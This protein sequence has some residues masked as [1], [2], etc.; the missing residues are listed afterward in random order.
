[1]LKL[2]AKWDTEFGEFIP[3]LRIA[4]RH[5]RDDIGIRFPAP[6]IVDISNED[7]KGMNQHVLY[8]K[9]ARIKREMGWSSS[10]SSESMMEQIYSILGEAE[11]ILSILVPDLFADSVFSKKKRRRPEIVS[12]MKS[13]MLN[14]KENNGELENNNDDDDVQWDSDQ[15]ESEGLE[16]A[17]SA[18]PSDY[19]LVVSITPWS[20]T[21]GPEDHE[22]SCNN[23]E[24]NVVKTSL[25]E[26]SKLIR[27]KFFPV[28]KEWIDV[29]SLIDFSALQKGNNLT[30]LQA[31]REVEQVEQL[32]VQAQGIKDDI[33]HIL[34]QTD[35]LL[36]IS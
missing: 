35:N 18:L 28:V 32:L 10:S 36:G 16:H 6:E 17:L 25:M 9:L 24:D 19:E 2:L 7:D 4:V 23:T 29:L 22:V 20:N 31:K 8:A 30:P 14:Q 26:N 12:S 33:D 34:Q 3:V 13:S 11:R 5:L 15:E 1:L 21:S 27:T